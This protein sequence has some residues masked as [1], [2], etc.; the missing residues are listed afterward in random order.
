MDTEA[1]SLLLCVCVC[2]LAFSRA[3]LAIY[4]G[5]QAR[6][7]I[8]AV[9]TGLC[10]TNSNSGSKPSLESIPQLTAMLDP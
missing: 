2:L 4:G 9:A 10:Q 8:A 7:L 5:S 3:A 1:N 6:G